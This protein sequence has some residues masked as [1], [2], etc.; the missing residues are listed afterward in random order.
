MC[1]GFI[2][3]QFGFALQNANASRIFQNLGASIEDIPL[4]WLAAPITGLLIQPIIGFVSDKTWSG[5]GRRRPFL[6]LGAIL[7]SIALVIMPNSAELWIAVGMLWMLD[8][9][10]NIS[11]GPSLAL[12]G[13]MLPKNQLPFGFS[14]QSFFVGISAVIASS[15][16]WILT[17]IFGVANSAPEGQIPPSVI[18]SFYLG[19]A[20]MLITIFWTTRS[21]R[22]YS[23]EELSRFQAEPQ[24]A[25]HVVY[26]AL[27]FK[28][29]V[30]TGSVFL[31]LGLLVTYLVFHF[32]LD[33]KLFILAFSFLL[34]GMFK[35]LAGA[36]S[37]R[38]NTDNTL[39][40]ISHD[41][42]CMPRIMRQLA[43]VQF[44][45]W[46][47][48]FCMWIYATSAVT[49]FHFGTTDPSSLKYNQGANW[50]GILFAAYN[51]CA[52]IA[53][54]TI[55]ALVKRTN[56]I[57]AHSSNLV[58]G[59][60]ALFSFPF[61]KEPTWL[62][63]P[64]VGLGFA[65]ASI[66]TLPFSI[67]TSTLPQ[68]KLGVYAGLFNV[69]IVLPQILA[70]SILALIIRHVFAGQTIYVMVLAGVCMLLA[71]AATF[72]VDIRQL[73]PL[74]EMKSTANAQV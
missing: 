10:L 61:I 62:L 45:S 67:L 58:L 44:L 53:A 18:Y 34:F 15:L 24:Q 36:M 26:R 50:V 73:S 60:I 70:S 63:I 29:F 3:I 49:S 35:L 31:S 16:P 43:T 66:L 32:A 27:P 6:L 47:G 33:K 74:P 30:T 48:L 21:T 69:F 42:S 40:K 5:L 4:L 37:I 23:A 20:I 38:G 8:A 71:A 7:A 22:E 54:L 11:L 57:T 28:T 1:F 64:M 51:A 65:W 59:A 41:L 12:V 17:N 14:V 25:R 68:N 46:F 39:Y 56:Q 2:G 52:A 13:D 19:G 55:P 72:L 9:A